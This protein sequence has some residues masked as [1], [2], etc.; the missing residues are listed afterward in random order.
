MEERNVPVPRQQDGEAF[1]RG[2]GEAGG[3]ARSDTTS[4][5]TRRKQIHNAILTRRRFAP[6]LLHPSAQLEKLRKE[7]NRMHAKMTRDRKKLFV[8]SIEE[9]I[10]RLESDNEKMRQALGRNAEVRQNRSRNDTTSNTTLPPPPP[11][12]SNARFASRPQVSAYSQEQERLFNQ[13]RGDSY[14]HDEDRYSIG[15]DSDRDDENEE[16]GKKQ[17]GAK[18]RA[19]ITIITIVIYLR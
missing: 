17:R 4:C 9:A 7:R 14:E 19:G 15:G 10:T 16:L 3:G 13:M 11:H 12:L 1:E 5:E 18:R 8:A 2:R 6:P